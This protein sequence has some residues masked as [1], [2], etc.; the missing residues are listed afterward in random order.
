MRGVKDIVLNAWAVSAMSVRL[1]MKT[2]LLSDEGGHGN[3]GCDKGREDRWLGRKGF[4]LIYPR[5]A[6]LVCD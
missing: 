4:N 3:W 1:G 5:N 6:V 2:L